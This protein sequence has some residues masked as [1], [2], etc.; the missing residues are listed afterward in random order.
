MLWQVLVIH[1]TQREWEILSP[2]LDGLS[3]KEK[4]RKDRKGW[5]KK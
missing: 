3:L 5:K 2:V 4:E 1:T